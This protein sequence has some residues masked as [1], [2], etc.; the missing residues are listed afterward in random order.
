MRST[1]RVEGQLEFFVHTEAS[2]VVFVGWEHQLRRSPLLHMC[3]H[4]VIIRDHDGRLSRLQGLA[5]DR[6]AAGPPSSP[7][8]SLTTAAI[9]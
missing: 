7:T 4:G 6:W 5:R 3:A 8:T 1:E 9:D 2:F